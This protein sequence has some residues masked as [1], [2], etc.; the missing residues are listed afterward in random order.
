MAFL[1]KT[2]IVFDR[3]V[4]VRLLDAMADVAELPDY[5][6]GRTE[7]P[8]PLETM[9]SESIASGL[10]RNNVKKEWA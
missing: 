8:L 9:L 2:K 5:Q 1:V 4:G 10:R 6:P 7:I 3:N